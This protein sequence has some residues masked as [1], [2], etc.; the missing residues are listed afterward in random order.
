MGITV[1]IQRLLINL[2]EDVGFV[3]ISVLVFP[4]SFKEWGNN[5]SGYFLL[6][7]DMVLPNLGSGHRV[8]NKLGFQA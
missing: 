3:S 2:T 5:P 7:W 4:N 8:R 1:W 6:K